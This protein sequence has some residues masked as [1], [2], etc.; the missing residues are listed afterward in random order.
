MKFSLVDGVGPVYLEKALDDRSDLV[1][2]VPVEG[3]DAQAHDISDVEDAV[4]FGSLQGEFSGQ[5]LAGLDALLDGG[6][7]DA[8]IGKE[9]AQALLQAGCHLGEKRKQGVVLL[10]NRL[11]MG[12]EVA[13][14]IVYVLFHKCRN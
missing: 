14:G 3:Y 6:H 4:V 10:E 2:V 9:T 13:I 5:G 12:I 1:H 7:H 8:G 11:A